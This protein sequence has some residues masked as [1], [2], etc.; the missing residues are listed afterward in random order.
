[1]CGGYLSITQEEME[2]I[3]VALEE[4]NRRL[5]QQGNPLEVLGLSYDSLK[6]IVPSLSVPVIA[7]DDGEIV[8][9][10]MKWGFSRWD[11]KGSVI[12]ARVESIESKPFFR[13]SFLNRRCI[14]PSRGFYEWKHDEEPSNIFFDALR[15][16]E[17]EKNLN[18]DNLQSISRI[19]AINQNVDFSTPNYDEDFVT[20]AYT[21]SNPGLA[22]NSCR[23]N[24]LKYNGSTRHSR[25]RSANSQKYLIRKSDSDIFLMA[26]IYQIKGDITEFTIITMPAAK[27]LESIHDRM[28]MYIETTNIMDW[29]TSADSLDSILA[30]L[31]PL[32]SFTALK[33]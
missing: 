29:L 5:G 1:M 7:M 11:G 28:P 18:S 2:E 16:M 14:I 23:N 22:G 31:S 21:G 6:D 9:K 25:K 13:E 19:E 30:S 27:S 24:A 10:P 32:A 3:R 8:V 26:G 33:V 12:N 20:Q 15:E 4:E 17:S